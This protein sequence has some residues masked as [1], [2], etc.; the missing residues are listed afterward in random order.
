MLSD[1]LLQVYPCDRRGIQST[2]GSLFPYL[3]VF[4]L[5]CFIHK[6]TGNCDRHT[7]CVI[8]L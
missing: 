1:I 5:L 6:C 7:H 2:F 8:I 4:P 3:N